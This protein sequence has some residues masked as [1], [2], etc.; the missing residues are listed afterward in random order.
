MTIHGMVSFTRRFLLATRSVVPALFLLLVL[1]GATLMAQ[2]DAG[3]VV[4][5]VRDPSGAL[6]ANSR[7]TLTSLDTG[8]VIEKATNSQ[9][10]YTFS[11]VKIGNY[12]VTVQA[13]GFERFERKGITVSAQERVLVDVPVTPGQASETI[14]VTGDAPQLQT[15]DA[16]VGQTID[17]KKIVDMPLNGRNF[18]FLAQLSAGVN[19]NQNDS[20]GLGQ[21][22]SFA[23]NGARPSQN[24]YL[25]DG[26]DN[27]SNLVDFL[28]G[29]AYAVLPPPDAIQEFKIQTSNYSAEIGRSAGAV[30]NA[31]VKAGTNSLHGSAWEFARNDIFDA[32]NYFTRPG[33]SKGH[34]S[35]NQFGFTLGGPVIKNHTFLFGDYQGLR[36]TQSQSVASSVPTALE[37]SSGFTNYS[38]LR[39]AGVYADVLGRTSTS[40]SGI[41]VTGYNIGTIFDPATTRPVICGV[42]DTP[43]GIT[44]PC[45]T[46]PAGTQ[47]GYARTPFNN[48]IIPAGRLDANAVKLASLFPAATSAGLVN[49]YT[50]ARQATNSA[51]SYD[52]RADQI[53]R[54]KD[55]AF[56]RFSYLKNPQFIPGPFTGIAD[57]GGFNAG[58]TKSTSYHGVLA[59]THT[60]TPTLINQARLGLNRLESSRLQPNSDV[61]GIPAQFG[62]QGVPQT[63]TNGGLGR[64][65]ISNYSL[66]GVSFLPSVEYSTVVQFSDDVTKT[67]GRNTIKMG[68]TY[69]HLRFSVLQPVASRGNYNFNGAFTDTPAQTGGAT[70]LAQ[71][72]LTP[73][74]STVGGTN[75]LGG[76]ESVQASNLNNTDM[77]RTYNGAYFQDDYKVTPELTLN[78]GLRWELFGPLIER[79]GQQTNFQPLAGG[80]ANYLF[81]QATCN[82]QLSAAFLTAAAKDKVNVVCS[83]QAGLQQVQKGNFS[84]RVG[85]AYQISPKLVTRAGYGIFY[86]GFENSSQYTFGDFPFQFSLTY[87]NPTPNSPVV[88]PNSAT[89]SLEAGIVNISTVPSLV[90]AS[91]VS[92]Q[93]EDFKI[94]TPYNQNYNLS[95]QYQLSSNQSLTLGYVGNVTRH[96]GV[97]IAPNRPSQILT[98]GQN[99]LS[100]SPYPDFG[101][102]GNYTTFEAMGNYNG[103]QTTYEHR[104]SHGLSVLANFTYSKCMTNGRDFLNA[105]AIGSFRAATLPGFGIAGDYGA[106]DFDIPRVVHLS[107][108]YEL[109]VGR[110]RM[111]LNHASRLVDAALGGWSTNFIFTAEDG[112]PGTIR[113]SVTTTTTYGCFVNPVAGV[114]RYTKS[115]NPTAATGGFLVSN[116][117]NPAAFANA[118]VATVNGQTDYS[119][120]GGGPSQY[121]GPAFR[122]L[123]FSVFKNFRITERVGVQ[124]RAETFNLTNTPNFANPSST[125]LASPASFGQVT[126]LRDAPNGNRQIQLAGKLYF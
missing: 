28:N 108:T 90:S 18:T 4:G 21:S 100:F 22:G 13:A 71:L 50:A 2:V 88:F 114:N 106:C 84:P 113:C 33:V 45:G 98:P 77:K 59:E 37:V 80:G 20:R 6:V 96:L 15:Q 39:Q 117:L 125:S 79:R 97:Y 40:P 75:N 83:S 119:P 54:D 78:L 109:P 68:Y 27:N 10:E 23:A 107:G 8:Q 72:V 9:G 126:T 35:Q 41:L 118:P 81:A 12:T 82:T 110:D 64:Y 95:F 24:N 19:Q 44:A 121:R 62:I 56:A 31:S 52:V 25:L 67:L 14:T 61:Q 26:I 47:L 85:L 122:R 102:G 92:V 58:T 103:L 86:G 43:T 42:M 116:F 32:K 3:S 69:E 89:G 34:F 36:N 57:G 46:K 73:T 66:G 60:F 70:G 115:P 74:A 87:T 120:L 65:N 29:T 63:G 55:S 7:V 49:N 104:L 105:T 111:F 5:T 38:E 124:F 51:N 123:E 94:R 76:P 101:T 11:P 1:G 112:Q 16:S 30:L 48:N 99:S 93:G 17:A 91:G 53:F